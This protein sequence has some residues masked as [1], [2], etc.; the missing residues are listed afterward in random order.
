[1]ARCVA[2]HGVIITTKQ[3]KDVVLCVDSR[4]TAVRQAALDAIQV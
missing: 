4:D 3:V 2:D 1:M